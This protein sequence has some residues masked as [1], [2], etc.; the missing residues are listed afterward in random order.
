MFR[1]FEANIKFSCLIFYSHLKIQWGYQLVANHS[2]SA[3]G[4]LAPL[5]GNRY[6]RVVGVV[7]PICST[8]VTAHKE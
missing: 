2:F 3:L 7:L 4:G 5:S 6:T 1:H 8:S